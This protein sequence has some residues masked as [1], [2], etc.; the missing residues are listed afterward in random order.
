MENGR[1]KEDELI[2]LLLTEPANVSGGSGTRCLD[3]NIADLKAQIAAN[4][5]VLSLFGL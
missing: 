5:K 2:N 3:D 1:F 4:H